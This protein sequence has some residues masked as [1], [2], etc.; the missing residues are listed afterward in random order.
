MT[1]KPHLVSLAFAGAL[2]WSGAIAGSASASE[3]ATTLKP[4][5]ARLGEIDVCRILFPW[6]QPVRR[7]QAEVEAAR[8]LGGAELRFLVAAPCKRA[9][10]PVD[11]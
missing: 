2:L 9:A 5:A 8:F 6:Y 1:A 10:A 3:A 11:V 4:P 7:A